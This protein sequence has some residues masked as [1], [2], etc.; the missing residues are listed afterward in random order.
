M[1]PNLGAKTSVGN[2]V[3]TPRQWF[4]RFRQITKRENKTD[5]TPLPGMDW[6]KR[7]KLTIGR[8]QFSANS[9]SEREKVFS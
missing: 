1:V 4:E 7:L 3:S 5:I 9:Q 8:L 2:A 6:M